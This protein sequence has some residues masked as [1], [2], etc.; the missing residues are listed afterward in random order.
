MARHIVVRDHSGAGWAAGSVFTEVVIRSLCR[1]GKDKVDITVLGGH[2]S[3]NWSDIA[4]YAKLVPEGLGRRIVRR[5]GWDI[6]NSEERY[7][8]KH[9]ASALFM[10]PKYSVG[11][12][13]FK[14]IGWIPD[15]QHKHLPQYFS[16]KEIAF[17]NCVNEV[18]VRNADIVML[19]SI[20]A[21]DDFSDSFPQYANK[22]RAN[23]F[24][25]LYVFKPLSD[26][27]MNSPSK[28]HLP[29]KFILVANQFWSHKNHLVVI[30]A[31]SLLAKKGIKINAVFT[32]LPADYRDKANSA[33][34]GIL[35]NIAK[36]KLNNIIV[37]LGMV[38]RC[39]L[40]DLMR[41]AC[42]VLQPSRFEGWSTIV[43]DTL[44]LG[45]PLMC[46][47]IPVHRE[48]APDALAF[49][50]CDDVQG[51]ADVLADVWNEL[52]PGPDTVSEERAFAQAQLLA[53][54]HGK[55][56]LEFSFD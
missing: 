31:I 48:Q 2:P 29:E 40:T 55:T 4:S 30:K 14:R 3:D 41:H 49:F 12:A 18:R 54:S 24:P 52:T 56:L 44:T 20:T 37:P 7:C 25:S 6:Y 11:K 15:F 36:E 23:P 43:Q 39:D 51:L 46:S 21:L 17:R 35:Q 22:G 10:V 16:P 50:K 33:V 34:S 28:Y 47:D 27:V 8:N 38:P 32:G 1:A 13:N 53:N 5:A 9:A 26:K 42:M 45:R 19:S